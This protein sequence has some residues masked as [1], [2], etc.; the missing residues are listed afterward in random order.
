[1]PS[2]TLVV[3]VAIGQRALTHTY[4]V[5]SNRAARPHTHVVCAAIGQRAP[6]HIDVLCTQGAVC[7][8]GAGALVFMHSLVICVLTGQLPSHALV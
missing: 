1:M 3:C 4:G 8:D 5:C 7:A 2:H 6:A